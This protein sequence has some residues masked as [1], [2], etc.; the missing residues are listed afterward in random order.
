MNSRPIARLNNVITI[1]LIKKTNVVN[2]EGTKQYIQGEV[3][4]GGREGG[5]E[6]RK[7]ERDSDSE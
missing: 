7:G 5:R 3:G 2:T 6:R 1:K 4:E